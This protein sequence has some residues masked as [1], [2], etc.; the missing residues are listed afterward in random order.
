MTQK[1]HIETRN[2]VRVLKFPEALFRVRI[3]LNAHVDP[4]LKVCL[5]S[6]THPAVD[7]GFAIYF[8]PLFNMNLFYHVI[9]TLFLK[10]LN[11]LT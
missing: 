9:G 6:G 4:D 1:S 10:F 2:A 7:P 8:F 3:V 11:K 5:K